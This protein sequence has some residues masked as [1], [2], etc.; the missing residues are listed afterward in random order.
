MLSC[1]VALG[2]SIVA[3]GATNL[4]ATTYTAVANTS[5]NELDPA[6]YVTSSF[7]SPV[8]R[9]IVTVTANGILGTVSTFTNGVTPAVAQP[10][11]AVPTLSEWMLMLLASALLLL[12]VR[13]GF[14]SKQ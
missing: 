13:T 5:G 4:P 9:I 12:A 11:T 1:L 3:S 7:S 10:T 2:A 6:L 8:D 14:R